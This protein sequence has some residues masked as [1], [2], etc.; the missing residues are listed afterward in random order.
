MTQLDSGRLCAFVDD[1]HR[2][3]VSRDEED[4]DYQMLAR[5]AKLTEEVGELSEQLLGK[6]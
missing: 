4:H 3:L 5:L 6:L 2:Y 1:V